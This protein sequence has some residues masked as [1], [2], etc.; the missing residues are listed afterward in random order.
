MDQN[1]AFFVPPLVSLAPVQP[2]QIIPADTA[3]IM[4]TTFRYSELLSYDFAR[5]EDSTKFTLFGVTHQHLIKIVY[6]F[7]LDDLNI[8]EHVGMK[9]DTNFDGTQMR[10]RVSDEFVIVSQSD[11]A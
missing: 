11:G 4:E 6:N 5:S 8:I 2:V 1:F 10:V 3:V 9:K 7:Y